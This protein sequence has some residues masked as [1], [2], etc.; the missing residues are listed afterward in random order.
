[1]LPSSREIAFHSA[2]SYAS[3]ADES[4]LQVIDN[5][6]RL[7]TIDLNAIR[8]NQN[9]LLS[10]T[11]T[12]TLFDYYKRPFSV[13]NNLAYISFAQND[14][15]HIID[16]RSKSEPVSTFHYNQNE[17]VSKSAFS[18][19]DQFLITGNERGRSY[20]ISPEDG[21]IQADLPITSDVISAVAISEEYKLAAY[22][23]FSHELIVYKI[24]SFSIAFEQKLNDIIEMMTFVDEDTLLAITRNG[25]ILKIDLFK[26]KVI[27]EMMLDQ[28]VWPSVMVLSHSK[29]FVYIGTRESILF[30]VYVK[31]LDIL[32]QVKLPYHGLTTL[33]RTQKNFIMGFKTGELLFY[34]HRE[35][36]E[37][38]ITY[39]K[40]K[41]IKEAC[42][43]FQK[44]I[45][46]MSHRETKKIYEYWLE[47]KETII[48]LLSRG[49][50]EQAQKIAEPFLFH[51]KCKLEFREIEELQPDLMAL[52]RYIRS[53]RYVLAYDL[54]KLKPE[55]RKSSLFTQLESL[56]NKNL[57][58]AQI[59]L[60]REPLLNKEAAQEN[61]RD[62]LDV[63]EKK[64][65]IE[66]MLKRSGIFTMA[67]NSVKEKNFS[68]Y[69]RL[70]AQ[71]IFLES[72]PL[73]QKVLQVGERIQNE[74][75]KY[76]EEKNYKQSLIL[77][78]ILHQFR[79]YQNQANRLKEVSKALLILEHQ[80]EHNM[81]F[82]AV[83]TQDQ[84]QLQSHYA[85]IEELEQMKQVFQ[86][87][88]MALI[89]EKEYAKAFSNIEPYMQISICKQNVANIIRK[90]YIAQLKDAHEQRDNTV[91]WEKS[92]LTYLKFFPMDKLLV[93]FAKEHQKLEVLKHIIIASPPPQNPIY[94]KNLVS[95]PT[96]SA[97]K[98][99]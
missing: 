36:E 28:S 67:E 15:E 47:E 81:L 23:S 46:L 8:I 53:M 79:P 2:I 61:L 62:F 70:V 37:Q 57:Q 59:L 10:N 63:E 3:V 25:K 17:T 76:L 86:T 64:P 89:E 77:S 60:A 31:T 7:H 99:S 87:E 84:F 32:Y 82:E 44:N 85:L 73:Y 19:N 34:N 75:L 35:F 49:D 4:T 16:T 14:M 27:Q 69:F 92:F 22:A 42:L 83:K 91:D 74:I 9:I 12:H 24:N 65:I 21:T 20:I 30:A 80:I 71:N 39:I 72:T 97:K 6:S 18:E 11:Y 90:I 88:Q 68:F 93:E 5:Q 94:P 33:S 45:F 96:P 43:I 55:L 50:I 56:W 1:M 58:K 41:Q 26:G 98:M 78:D 38:F 52:Q 51:P 48:N 54:A 29:K 66:N 40:L 13:G 95:A